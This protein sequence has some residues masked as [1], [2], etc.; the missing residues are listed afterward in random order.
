MRQNKFFS[1]IRIILFALVIVI[2]C[3]VGFIIPMRPTVSDSEGRTL[4]KFPEFTIESFLSGEYTS[5]INLWYSDT[6][7]ARDTLMD[8]NTSLKG[9]YGIKTE[10]FEG[11]G[12]KDEINLDETF[13]WDDLEKETFDESATFP[14]DTEDDFWEDMTEDM[15]EDTTEDDPGSDETEDMTEEDTSDGDVVT[16]ENTDNS[17]E[18]TTEN[19]T[20]TSTENPTDKPTETETEPPEK[21]VIDGYYVKGDS[22]YQLHYFDESFAKRYAVSVGDAAAKLNGIAQVYDIIVPTSTCIYL[23]D[24]DIQR[25]GASN[26]NDAIKYM[27]NAINSYSSYLMSEGKL[28]NPVKTLDLTSYLEMKKNEYIFFRTDHHWT[29][30]G[31]Y[32]ASRFFLDEVGRSYPSLDKYTTYRIDGFLGTLYKHTQNINLKNNPDTVYAYESPTVKKLT[33]FDKNKG[34]NIEDLIINPNVTSSNKYLCFS[35]GD[36]PYYEIHNETI[37]DGSAILVIKESYGN[38]FLPMIAD[39]YEYVYAIDYRFWDEDFVSFVRDRNIETVLF[40][41][42]LTATA[43]NY[44]IWTLERCIK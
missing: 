7:P 42:N 27:Y 15:T 6:F 5:K 34:E 3:V 12:E 18:T 14:M 29:G 33:V 17:V 32:Y 13:V 25:L 11:K 9:L 24:A 36:R 41:N 4:T 30:L 38:A 35:S 28:S 22:A 19:P 31:A 40:L 16:D 21:E 39:S 26:G 8:G 44:N 43:T 37:N 2:G 10:D 20:E 1:S 23:S